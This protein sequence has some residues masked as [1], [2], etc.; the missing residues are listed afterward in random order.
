MTMNDHWGYNKNDH[1]WKSTEDLVRKLV[2]IASKG[3]NFL[4]NVGPTAEGVFPAPCVERLAAM[5]R[6]MKVNGESIYGTAASPFDALPFGRC[7]VKRLPSGD[8]DLY[9]HVFHWPADGKLVVPA[10]DNTVKK[11]WLLADPSG[12]LLAAARAGTDVMVTLPAAPPDPIDSV[13]V[14]RVAGAPVVIRAPGIEAPSPIF[15]DTLP[16]RITTDVP[17]SEI[18]YTLDGSDPG[19]SSLRCE[20]VLR[21]DRS[22]RVRACVCRGGK[23]ISPVAEAAF[24]KQAPRP[25][26]DPAGKKRG[27]RYA[28][29]E[30]DWKALPDFKR[31]APKR[32]GVTDRFRI[33]LDRRE[34]HF[35]FRFTGY[36]Q[37]PADGVYRFY[38]ESDDGSRLYVGDTLLVE[39]DGL[40][41]PQ[42]RSAEIAL[43][44]GLHPLTVCMFECT[45][46]QAL[47]VSISGPGMKK[48]SL[49]AEMLYR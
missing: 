46:G 12:P 27:L 22:A 28:Y 18:R 7:T 38:V 41:G 11:A 36:V 40:H 31:L 6:W 26:V 32:T 39:N 5:G 45:G 1:H 43:A 9:L 4:L 17:G 20:G 24:E 35:A 10:L 34:E 29:Y 47:E 15:I 3:G 14:L 48:R 49:P 2:D 21:L 25:A 44:A 8:S 37:V 33:D 13:V 19:P 23:R 30:G 16:V 42:E